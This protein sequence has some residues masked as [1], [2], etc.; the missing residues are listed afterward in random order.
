MLTIQPN[1]TAAT[2]QYAQKNLHFKG[3]DDDITEEYVKGKQKFYEKQIN[4][5]EKIINNKKAPDTLK[6]IMKGIKVVSE[7]IIEGW[8]VLWGAKKGAN[9]AKSGAI[10]SVNS[11]FA[12]SVG[13]GFKAFGGFIAKG[14]EKLSQSGL[15]EK[16]GNLV[17]KLNNT[18]FGKYIVST[19]KAVVKAVKAAASFVKN[20]FSGI[21]G[22]NI[23][24]TY[25][26]VANGTATTLGVGS[27]VAGTYSAAKAEEKKTAEEKKKKEAELKNQALE[28]NAAEAKRADKNETDLDTELENIDEDFEED[29]EDV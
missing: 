16:A 18:K 10:S 12:K 23:E 15:A 2:R 28:K 9:F 17:E 29:M 6:K 21:K 7:G 26:K 27:G 11:K 19:G 25:D 4:D 24:K 14:F 1:V 5:S 8:A 22:E 13:K 3:V 20:K